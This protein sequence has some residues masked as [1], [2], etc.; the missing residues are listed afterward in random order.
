MVAI[1]SFR[2][3]RYDP[4]IAG[5][6]GR[7][8]AP[9]YDVIDAQEQERLYRASPHNIVRLILGKQ[10]PAD[11]ETDN[12]YTRACRDYNAWRAQGVLQRDAIP[13]LYA[14]EHVF[15][16]PLG[17]RRSR[18][19]VIAVLDV[20][21]G[22]EGVLKHERTLPGPKEDRTRLLE[23]VPA[24]LEPIFCVYPDATGGMQRQLAAAAHRPPLAAATLGTEGVRLWAI[25]DPGLI[26]AFARHLASSPVLIADGHHRF[27]VG[28]ANRDCCRG[29]M[30]YFVSMADPALVV[31]PIHRL[32]DRVPGT[33]ALGSVC[34][35][36]PVDNGPAALAWVL[37]QPAQQG[38]FGY[39]EG[40]TAYRVRVRP[41]AREQWVAGS[42]QPPELAQLDVSVLHGLVLPATGVASEQVRY[43]GNPSE[44]W[45]ALRSGS[46]KASWLLREIPLPTIFTL[47]EAGHVMPP[48]STYF[49]PKVPSGLTI[50]PFE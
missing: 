50:H 15:T 21:G 30:A 9:P 3:L 22:V 6:L 25:Q 48:K 45:A 44:V 40:G 2:A 41:A 12:R 19:G 10:S 42:G 47:A 4:A 35:V 11:T 18:L 31:H 24:N 7:V 29:L 43:T 32:L 1:R 14:V 46:A 37:G 20:N 17:A 34:E 38:C 13:A 33:Q 49:Y 8:I 23:A 39:C 5:E 16:D 28:V 36:E 26:A 27:E